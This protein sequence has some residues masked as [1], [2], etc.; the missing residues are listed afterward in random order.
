[1]N[2]SDEYEEIENPDIRL[3]ERSRKIANELGLTQ[4][5]QRRKSAA[6]LSDFNSSK[7][8]MPSINIEM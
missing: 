3:S 4:S 7:K 1:M 2:S 5:T 6:R 8:S